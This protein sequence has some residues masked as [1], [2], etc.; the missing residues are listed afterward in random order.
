M[1]P[2]LTRLE[3]YVNRKRAEA[4]P[5]KWM[6]PNVHPDDCDHEKDPDE[7]A[8]LCVQCCPCD[9]CGMTRGETNEPL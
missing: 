8:A 5:G 9:L 6:P 7:P 3:Y 1:K 4:V 2:P